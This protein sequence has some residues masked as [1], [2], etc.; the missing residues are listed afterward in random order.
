MTKSVR[1]KDHFSPYMSDARWQIYASGWSRELQGMRETL[2]ALGNG[3]V[4]SRGILEENSK[5]CCPGTFFAG[6]FDHLT[7]QVPEL[8][9]APNPIDLRISAGGQKLDV[10]AMEVLDHRRVLDMRRAALARRT[11]YAN[12]QKQR[13]SYQSLRYFS[14]PNKHL[15]VMRVFLQP[16]DGPATFTVISAVN[17]AM[18]N[19]GII[20]E[21]DKKH[22]NIHEVSKVGDVNYLCVKTFE[23]ATHL[24]YGTLME[25]EH[26]NR[27]IRQPQRTFQLHLKRGE[28]AC[29]TYYVSLYTSCHI[30]PNRIKKVSADCVERAAKKGFDQLFQEHAKAWAIR[31]KRADIAI[32]GDPDTERALRFN[33]YHLMTMANESEDACGIGA[34]GLSGEG[35]RGHSFWDTEIFTLPYF[36][37]MFPKVAKNL[38]LY[39]YNRLPAAREIAK[40]N[41][42][43][44]AMFPWESADTGKETTP[45][46][47]KD[48]DGTIKAINT[49]QM[50]QHIT[51][52]IAYATL[53]Y[54]FF[55]GDEDFMLKHGLE[56]VVE[57]ARFWT[58]R[59]SFNQ[60]RNYYEIKNIIGPDEFHENVNN[61]AYTNALASWN[62]A[63]AARIYRILRG[64]APALVK[65]LSERLQLRTG[66]AEEWRRIAGQ[67]HIKR[68][69]ELIE[70][71]DG[72]FK[73]RNL[74]LPELDDFFIPALPKMPVRELQK[75]Q[76]VKQADVVMLHFLLTDEFRSSEIKRNFDYYEA[77][78]L[79][80][81]SLSPSIHAAVAGRVNNMVKARR[82]LNASLLT[83]LR[84]VHGNTHHGI[85]AACLG[86]SWQAVILGFGGTR[87]CRGLLH[88]E[89][90]LPHHW[91]AL[92]YSLM[93]H[94][95]CVWV[96]VDQ[97]TIK[98]RWEPARKRETLTVH[99]A[100]RQQRL[101]A[102]RAVTI[103][104][105]RRGSK[106]G[107]YKRK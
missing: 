101:P 43:E 25:V 57:T 58:S 33:V 106:K 21:G 8:V 70:A 61:N 67:I 103:G 66:E 95:G 100:G 54:Y 84:N 3:Y 17:A 11:I 12:A 79:H 5:G 35:Y 104:Y 69:G 50:E 18:V 68:R 97:K 19:K 28:T 30:N 31:W 76:Y 9:N 1:D 42:Y 86:G 6:V 44:G 27:T 83:D 102:Q 90:H 105:T 62:L 85:H 47:H 37:Y 59:V 93:W 64:Q 4:G 98:L 81:S 26:R 45:E 77:R 82:Y 15:A 13:F 34:K 22:V 41:G 49:G 60:R 99:V 107:K 78:T 71:F 89:P 2:F 16:L 14:L 63:M 24:A 52:D 39:R 51:A 87:I 80:K 23:K 36:V 29:L 55:T 32:A 56:M 73:L 91:K 75:T 94:G 7:S 40:T 74:P 48:L 20:T 88:F 72:Y 38:L 65:K 53:Q 96:T 46:W 10:T 92:S